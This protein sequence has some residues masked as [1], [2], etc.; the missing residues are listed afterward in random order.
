MR[1]NSC[2]GE[3]RGRCLV[4]Q[5]ALPLQATM[6][7]QLYAQSTRYHSCDTTRRGYA[8][9]GKN[10]STDTKNKAS[11]KGRPLV[12]AGCRME[13][14]LETFLL[15]SN[16]CCHSSAISQAESANT[17]CRCS[18]VTPCD[19][20]LFSLTTT[21]P[22]NSLYHSSTGRKPA[23]PPQQARIH[24]RLHAGSCFA[25]TKDRHA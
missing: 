7:V 10:A 22:S 18:T 23:H 16:P 19:V 1:S 3:C 8:A 24:I 13:L 12:I 17:F 9:Y 14:K 15:T 6:T 21:R 5:L 20:G 2:A 25:S 4:L 11:R